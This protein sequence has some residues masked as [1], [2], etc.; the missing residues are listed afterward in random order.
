MTKKRCKHCGEEK[1]LIFMVKSSNTKDGYLNVCKG[2]NSRIR[3]DIEINSNILKYCPICKK[4]V[5][6][7]RFRLN[8]HSIE[9]LKFLCENCF[10][11][12]FVEDTK[13]SHRFLKL[14]VQ[15]DE[16]YKNHIK[17]QSRNSRLKHF[18]KSMLRSAK[19]RAYKNNLEFNLELSDIIIPEVCPILEKPF[20]FGTKENYDFSPSLDRI[21]N[22]KGYIK[23][24]IRVI[25]KKANTMK[26]NATVEELTNFCKNI[27]RY[28]LNNIEEK[29]IELEDKEPLR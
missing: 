17:V 8:R 27:I 2:C 7:T 15:V 5:S 18:I 11:D 28:S 3:N 16:E 13:N 19:T 14:R 1:D 25:S 26:N 4:E 9:K 24:N 22:E 20:S 10:E 21:N 6:I 29:D 23:G 12:N